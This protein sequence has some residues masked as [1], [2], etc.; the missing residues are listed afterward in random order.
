MVHVLDFAGLPLG[1]RTPAAQR[2][3][4]ST[5]TLRWLLPRP[6]V[7]AAAAGPP[8]ASHVAR[9]LIASATDLASR[10]RDASTSRRS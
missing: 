5:S 7:V 8:P 3:T 1:I 9:V 10:R 4:E 2:F 6:P